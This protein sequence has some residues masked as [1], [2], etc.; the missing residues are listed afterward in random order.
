MIKAVVVGGLKW[1]NGGI[2]LFIR[3]IVRIIEINI[4]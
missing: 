4:K 2:C 1:D 3:R